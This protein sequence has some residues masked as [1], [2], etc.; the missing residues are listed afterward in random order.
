MSRT[1][2]DRTK[3]GMSSASGMRT[4]LECV[5][6]LQDL[7]DVAQQLALVEAL[8]DLLGSEHFCDH[9]VRLDQLTQLA[10]LVGR[11]QRGALHDAIRVLA[12]QP[13]M[14]DEHRQKAAARVQAEAALDVVAHSFRPYDEAVDD[15]PEPDEHVVE[16]RGG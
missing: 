14:L 10:T 4:L 16:Q 13:A 5:K 11:A 2:P 1:F 9:G 15:L 12:R 8:G 6:T 7:L 3:P